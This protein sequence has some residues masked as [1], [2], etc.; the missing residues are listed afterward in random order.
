MKRF[1]NMVIAPK[2]TITET[3]TAEEAVMEVNELRRA[4]RQDDTPALGSLGG[5]LPKALYVPKV[6]VPKIKKKRPSPGQ[7][8]VFDSEG[9]E[10]VR[11]R[12][13]VAPPVNLAIPTSPQ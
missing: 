1:D 13:E 10:W 3:T 6:K 11:R 9:K 7:M 8:R 12:K 4:R 2:P 5:Q